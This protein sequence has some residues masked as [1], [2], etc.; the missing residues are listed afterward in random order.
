MSLRFATLALLTFL[1]L[2]STVADSSTTSPS[3][4]ALKILDLT[5]ARGG[6]RAEFDSSVDAL[7]EQLKS[8][9]FPAAGV[10]EI[11][12]AM[13]A[14]FDNSIRWDELNP[15]LAA[16]YDRHF[17][18]EELAELAAFFETPLGRKT[19]RALPAL[20]LEFAAIRQEYAATKQ[21]ALD[22]EIQKI[23]RHYRR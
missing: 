5:D 13:G 1:P 16:L 14:W 22:E 15:Q 12:A 3:A 11:R 18:A 23:V 6:L 20:S 4:V 21:A 7:T 10:A 2:A 17:S 9:G 19:A 8:N